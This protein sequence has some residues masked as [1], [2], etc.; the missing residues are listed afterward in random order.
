L[1]GK[2]LWVFF[3]CGNFTAVFEQVAEGAFGQDVF[4]IVV[5]L[6]ESLGDNAIGI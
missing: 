6:K 2:F 4:C 5:S 1:F 3:F